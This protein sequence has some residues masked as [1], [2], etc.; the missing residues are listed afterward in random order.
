EL[1][2]AR[3]RVD[4]LARGYQALQNDREDFKLRLGR[5]RDR[6]LDVERGT[7]ALALLEAID[8]LDLC[9]HAS[10]QDQSA[11]AA[12]VKLIREK[13]LA[14]AAA[15]GIERVPSVGEHFDPSWAEAA[16][17]EVTTDPSEDQKITA[18]IRAGYRLKG[19][20]IRPA[21]VRVAKYVQP[22]D[23]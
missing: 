16:D 7:V 4:E 13:L 8:E 11:L 23:A 22:A 1:E 21:R 5:E 17:M 10:G 18:E 2:A 19:R 3:R 15:L 12:G 14:R 9:L 20:V 6:L